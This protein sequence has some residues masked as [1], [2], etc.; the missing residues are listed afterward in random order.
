MNFG[1]NKLQPSIQ[2]ARKRVLIMSGRQPRRSTAL[3]VYKPGA[4]RPNVKANTR[5]KKGKK[6]GGGRRKD[7]VAPIRAAVLPAGRRLTQYQDWSGKNS[8][9]RKH[10]RLALTDPFS[11]GAVGARVVDSYRIPTATYHMRVSLKV[12]TNSSGDAC[13]AL[14]PSPCLTAVLPAAVWGGPTI[15]GLNDFTQNNQSSSA[16]GGKYI[17]PPAALA[18]VLTEYRTVSWGV[19]LLAKDT[20]T[21]TKG[22]V[23]VAMVPT[24]ENA[25]S[26]NTMETVTGTSE[27]I[28]EYTIGM[29]LNSINAVT[30]LPGV[31]TFSMQDLLRG[32]VMLNPVPTHA[33]F[34]QFK[35]TTDRSTVVW[36]SGQVLADE[37]VF[38]NT[39]GL[40]NATAG[41]RKDVASLRGG[42]ALIFFAT[43][44][45][46]STNE[47]DVEVVFHIEGTPNVVSAGAAGTLVPSSMRQSVGDTHT[48]ETI[49]SIASAAWNLFKY[50]KD[51]LSTAGGTRALALF[52]EIVD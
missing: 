42:R 21:S 22:K 16:P 40:V 31:R 13:F 5:N 12:I 1:S 28:G 20:A 44:M 25:P 46:A 49:I 14:L 19:R 26:W 18:T 51:P 36:N 9:D 32:E 24:T 47:F 45:P 38:N 8:A 6:K 17:V 39:T 50:I 41:G 35:G 29:P 27:S 52:P 3:V 23:Y 43:G 37:G 4:R 34:Y 33:S 30:N 10:F 7:A 2:P 48:V 15:I 11:I